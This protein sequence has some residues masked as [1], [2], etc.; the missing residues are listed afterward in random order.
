MTDDTT[1]LADKFAMVAEKLARQDK[2]IEMLKSARLDDKTR[3][4]ASERAIEDAIEDAKIR[5]RALE[6]KREETT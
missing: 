3:I 6:A 1:E 2:D 5:L 4:R